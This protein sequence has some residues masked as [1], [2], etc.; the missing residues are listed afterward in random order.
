MKKVES[1]LDFSRSTFQ[2]SNVVPALLSSTFLEETGGGDTH[3]GRWDCVC[4]RLTLAV[5]G[6]HGVAVV[7]G[8]TDLA[9][10]PGGVEKAPQALAGGDV[11]VSRLTRVHVAV[12]IAARAGAV[13]CPWVAVETTGTPEG[14]ERGV[15]RAAEADRGEFCCSHLSQ[16]LPACPSWHR[17]QTTFPDP[18]STQ[19][20]LKLRKGSV[21][22]TSHNGH[23][24]SP[25]RGT[26][27]R[28][29]EA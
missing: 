29:G 27:I 25:Y 28:D 4:A 24:F 16:L 18:S 22:S 23:G 6:K 21:L 9:V 17:S 8:P 20:G 10:S 14:A 15:R 19:V 13:G 11:T 26:E 2:H 3:R 12:T 5:L 1:N 7:T